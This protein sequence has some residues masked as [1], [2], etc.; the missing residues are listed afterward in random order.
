M[1][2][3]DKVVAGIV[4]FLV[5]VLLPVW[6]IAASGQAGYRPDPEIV[7]E[8]KQC[9]EAAQ[10][11]KHEHMQLLIDWKDSVVRYGIRTYVASDGKEYVISLTNTCM[12]CHPNKAEFCDRCHD[13]VGVQPYC[14]D[15]H[16]LPE[17]EQ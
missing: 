14:W 12:E 3:A 6:Y 5:L 16:N 15:C 2:D 17:E 8:E 7:T 11:M 13:Y 4:I 9:V 1:Y 10:Y